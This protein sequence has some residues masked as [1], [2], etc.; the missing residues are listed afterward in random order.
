MVLDHVQ[1][2]WASTRLQ[3]RTLAHRLGL[4]PEPALFLK[5]VLSDDHNRG[6]HVAGLCLFERGFYPGVLADR[7]VG[8][9]A[10]GPGPICPSG[11]SRCLLSRL[12][13]AGHVV[14]VALLVGRGHL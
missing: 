6:M 1:H 4:G 2:R 9:H 8:R 7:G 3:R 14:L 10:S 13:R 12:A 5:Y 11:S